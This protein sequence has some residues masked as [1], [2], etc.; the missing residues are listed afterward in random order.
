MHKIILTTCLLASQMAKPMH[1][2]GEYLK[3]VG[4]CTGAAVTY[5]ITANQ[6]G[7]RVSGKQFHDQVNKRVSDF[8]LKNLLL[9]ASP[10]KTGIMCGMGL[11]LGAPLAVVSRYGSWPH[12]GTSQLVMPL[13]LSF[14][15]IASIATLTG[16]CVDVDDSIKRS[17]AS[18]R[19]ANGQLLVQQRTSEAQKGAQCKKSNQELSK[20]E[21]ER[22]QQ[23]YKKVINSVYD[24][25]F[26]TAIPVV[27]G[28]YGYVAYKRYTMC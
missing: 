16:F 19:V 11:A 9:F 12:I 14:L 10:T 6:I 3:I 27:L 5:G 24:A 25:S 22:R 28:L 20:F 1:E 17:Y 4:L 21:E 8:S 18:N 26:I 7:I 23:G 13:S 2:S 15:T